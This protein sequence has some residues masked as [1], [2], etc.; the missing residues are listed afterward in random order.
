M[1]DRRMGQFLDHVDIPGNGTFF[2]TQRYESLAHSRH[3]TAPHP[4]LENGRDWI[5]ELEKM[6]KM[7]P[8]AKG[9]RSHSCVFSHIL[10]EWLSGNGYSYA[11]TNDQFGQRG[12]QPVKQ[13]WGI[14]H[15]PI[16]YMD[17]MDFSCR[18]FWNEGDGEPFSEAFISNALEDNGVYVFDFHPIHLLLNTPSREHYFSMRDKF[19]AGEDLAE[20]SFKGNGTMTFFDNLC[21]QIRAHKKQSYSIAQALDLST[22]D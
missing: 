17:N 2:C 20:L 9:W 13:P 7:F 3:E 22:T 19:K 14:W 4:V 1:D 5:A 12:I 18:H 11:S 15:F 16:Y 21:C 6:R 10:A 8:T